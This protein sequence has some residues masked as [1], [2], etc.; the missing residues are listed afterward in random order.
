MADMCPHCGELVAV[1]NGL[2]AY[3][4]WPKPLRVVCP[5]SKQLPRCAES[6]SRPLGNGKENTRF[7]RGP[8]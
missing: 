7:Q 6:D 2:T 8:L 1:K 4:D 3:H 5:G